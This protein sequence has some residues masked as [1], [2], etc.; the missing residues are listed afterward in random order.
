MQKKKPTPMRIDTRGK[1]LPMLRAPRP[2][3]PVSAYARSFARSLCGEE[4]VPKNPKLGKSLADA[5]Y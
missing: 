5:L 1:Y 2:G 3:N 4:S